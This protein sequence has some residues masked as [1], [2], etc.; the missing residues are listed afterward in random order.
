MKLILM[1]IQIMMQGQETHGKAVLNSCDLT[2]SQHPIIN[3]LLYAWQAT[4]S[5]L[6]ECPED[7]NR[8]KIH[9]GAT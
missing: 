1:N 9:T 4:Q 6:D 7:E 5:Y 3:L 2:S 8:K